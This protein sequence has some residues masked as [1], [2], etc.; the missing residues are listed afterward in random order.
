LLTDILFDE[1]LVSIGGL[2]L[3]GAIALN[4]INGEPRPS[5]EVA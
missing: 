5:S 4:A 3:F 2:G 1:F